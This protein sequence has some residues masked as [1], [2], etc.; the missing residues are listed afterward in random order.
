MGRVSV[1]V[2]QCCPSIDH[3]LSCEIFKNSMYLWE[4]SLGTMV[5]FVGCQGREQHN[6]KEDNVW[7]EDTNIPRNPL[8]TELFAYLVSFNPQIKA[9][10]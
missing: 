9:K 1:F 8:H 10:K 4:S 5:K 3:I 7:G 2:Y 6:G